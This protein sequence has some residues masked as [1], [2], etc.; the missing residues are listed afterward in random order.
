MHVFSKQDA[1][2]QMI[3][4]PNTEYVKGYR[5]QSLRGNKQE[6]L[7]KVDSIGL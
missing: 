2:L 1:N 6:G 7:I 5:E 4:I 3:E